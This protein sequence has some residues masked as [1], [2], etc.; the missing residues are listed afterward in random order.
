MQNK[1]INIYSKPTKKVGFVLKTHGYKGYFKLVITDDEY[2]PSDYLLVGINEK[3][4][5]FK[6]ESYNES[7]DLIKLKEFNNENEIHFLMS[8]AILDFEEQR[9]DNSLNKII[10]Y[11]LTDINS[12]Q[13]FVITNI[14]WIPNNPLIEIRNGF[15]DTL[16]PF[17]DDIIIE[18]DE[19][20]QTV[21]ANIPDGL[22]D[23]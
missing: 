12:K 16:I 8:C 2:L 9:E 6:I 20:K 19:E 5:P 21:V 11:E 17:H 10:G 15:K 7:S 3:F 1:A 4:V 13:S 22:L 23:I 18:I 14:D